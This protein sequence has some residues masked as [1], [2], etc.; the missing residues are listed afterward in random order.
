MNEQ[1][2]RNTPPTADDIAGLY[3][4]FHKLAQDPDMAPKLM[5]Y[6]QRRTTQIAMSLHDIRAEDI[7]ALAD[8]EQEVFL[9]AV[10]GIQRVFINEQLLQFEHDDNGQIVT[11]DQGVE[12][13]EPPEES[14]NILQLLGFIEAVTAAM[15]D[16]CANKFFHGSQANQHLLAQ[17]MLDA[18]LGQI[19]STS[20]SDHLEPKVGDISELLKLLADKS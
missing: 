11:N 3:E 7:E 2:E 5:H 8:Q 14:V 1:Q 19:A 18:L 17:V 12:V 13:T 10:N 15:F 20:R 16:V 9:R 6:L 4:R